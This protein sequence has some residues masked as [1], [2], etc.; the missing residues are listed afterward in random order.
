MKYEFVLYLSGITDLDG[1]MIDDL[2]E[3]GCDDGAIATDGSTVYISF[4]REAASLGIAVASAIRDV[5]AAG[6]GLGIAG[7]EPVEAA[8][9]AAV[10]AGELEPAC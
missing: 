9:A 4:H 7:I 8:L 5:L 10:R 6:H 2:Y 1:D 3:S